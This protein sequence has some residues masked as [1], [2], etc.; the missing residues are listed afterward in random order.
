[1]RS[2]TRLGIVAVLLFAC[3]GC[4]QVSKNVVREQI[5]IGY[6]QSFLGDTFRLTHVENSGAFLSLGASMP[7]AARVAVFQGG[8]A[9]VVAVLLYFALFTR[10]LDAWAI[11]GFTLL[12]ASGIGNLIDR[13]MQ[14]G[15]VTDFLNL[16]L[17][18][19]RTGIFNVADVVGVIGVVLLIVKRHS[20]LNDTSGKK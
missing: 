8:V 11:A 10:Q 20:A 14:D 18:P 19:L 13:V 16:G 9:I 5:A 2:L 7:E 6:S 12:A 4:D 15:R 3:V 1:M 17:G